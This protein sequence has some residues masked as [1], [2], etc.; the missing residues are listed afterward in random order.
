M[1]SYPSGILVSLGQLGRI[2]TEV[3]EW[4]GGIYIYTTF[5]QGIYTRVP[6]VLSLFFSTYLS[7]AFGLAGV[8][9]IYIL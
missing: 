2:W 7:W 8:L 4:G 6:F 5:S 3:D 1:T 9:Y